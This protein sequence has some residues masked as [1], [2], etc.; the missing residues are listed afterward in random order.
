[1]AAK[2]SIVIF[3]GTVVGGGTFLAAGVASFLVIAQLQDRTM[4]AWAT[5]S[6]EVAQ[7][8]TRAKNAPDA[9][10]VVAQRFEELPPSERTFVS[11]GR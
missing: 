1:M 6:A 5:R 7:V 2:L 8:S 11:I 4:Q 10:K 9:N 3:L